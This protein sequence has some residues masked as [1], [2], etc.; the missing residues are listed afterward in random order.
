MDLSGSKEILIIDD[1]KPIRMVLH[2][3]LE[4]ADSTWRVSE[5]E[6]GEEALR[7]TE[8]LENSVLIITDLEMPG[9][10]SREFLRRLTQHP[11]LAGKPILVLSGG[12]P[13]EI[14]ETYGQLKMVKLLQKPCPAHDIVEIARHLLKEGLS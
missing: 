12:F 9:L 4:Q 2:R 6:N 7:N 8:M 3:T 11:A 13:R 14:L 5:M 10:D 1:S